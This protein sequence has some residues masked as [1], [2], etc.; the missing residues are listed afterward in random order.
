VNQDGNNI[1]I[2]LGDRRSKYGVLDQQGE[3]IAEG[4]VATRRE[5]F[6]ANFSGLAKARMALAVGTHS[7][8]VSC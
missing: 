8:W 3:I 7:A 1:G 4:R 5:E 2:D 6:I